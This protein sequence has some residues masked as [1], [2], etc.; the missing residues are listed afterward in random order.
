MIKKKI[1]LY[2]PAK[3]KGL[4]GQGHV[5]IIKVF[6]P[7]FLCIYTNGKNNSVHN[8]LRTTRKKKRKS[9]GNKK[10]QK[11]QLW[12]LLLLH[13]LCLWT[14][15]WL[16]QIPWQQLVFWLLFHQEF[17]PYLH[18]F[19]HFPS[20]QNDPPTLFKV[21]PLLLFSFFSSL[22]LSWVSICF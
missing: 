8:P 6:Y 9:R 18:L 12:T 1:V 21:I 7:S 14:R 4:A 10:W 17:T 22:C 20:N 11:Q 19:L 5:L 16:L 13:I 15:F 3:G 2:P